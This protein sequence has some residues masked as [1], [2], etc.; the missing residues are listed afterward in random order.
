MSDA[1][2]PAVL[3]V[4]DGVGTIRLQK[5]PFNVLN[6]E[7]LA[8]LV[9]L[10]TEATD[11][12]DVRAVVVYGGERA[13]AAGADIKEMAAQGREDM[14]N[15][16]SQLL[17]EMGSTI[18]AIPKPTVTAVTGHALGGGCELALSTDIRLAAESTR[19][20]L[21][22][23]TLGI[24]P[25]A[26]GTQRLARLIGPSHAKRLIFEGRIL[27]ATEA[28]D[29]GIVDEVVPDEEV[30]ARAVDWAAR[31]ADGPRLALAAAKKAVDEGLGL[32]LSEG[33]EVERQVFTELF[34]TADRAIGMTAFGA[35]E[36]PEFT[37]R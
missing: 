30:Y 32:P 34:D 23:T 25:G 2:A 33:I 4:A 15:G 28:L 35:R 29:I 9:T 1:S 12:D 24:I 6:R 10:A 27:T 17:Q 3:E 8:C 22:E 26:G 31:F 37:G 5:P 21:P 20:G 18:A 36:I 7:L 16:Y 14:E 13:L 11:R 19:I